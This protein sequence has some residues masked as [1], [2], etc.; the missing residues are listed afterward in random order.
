MTDTAEL[1]TT[2]ES[3]AAPLAAGWPPPTGATPFPPPPPADLPEYRPPAVAAPVAPPVSPTLPVVP[4]VAAA[5]PPRPERPTALPDYYS[6]VTPPTP[7]RS[8]GTGRKFLRFVVVLALLGGL[9]AAGVVYGPGVLER[10]R[11]ERAG[12]EPGG[13]AA[14]PDESSAPLEFPSQTAPPVEV[15]NATFILDDLGPDGTPRRYEITTDFISRASRVLI[16]RD[17]LPTLEVLTLFD[18]AVVRRIDEDTWYQT[19]RGQFPLDDQLER[20]RWV[21]HLDEL[22][23]PANRAAAAIENSTTS[24]LA[25]ES[26]RH[27]VVSIDPALLAGPELTGPSL[28][29]TGVV[30]GAAGDATA[31]PTQ[32]TPITPDLAP[33]TGPATGVGPDGLPTDGAGADPAADV[34]AL[35]AASTGRAAPETISIEMWIDARGLIRQLIT[36]TPG[37][38]ETLTVT[39]VS[40][41]EWLPEFPALEQIEPLTASAL[42]KLGL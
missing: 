39:M 9:G 33:A 5:P 3:P 28:R 2:R 21:R 20:D 27:L 26:M 11:E 7:K 24:Q 15:R 25:G 8:R 12:G 42:V 19:P 41:D 32:A 31:A 17:E 13:Q 30:G 10:I 38:D 40:A 34:G 16:D 23:P 14:A 37:G 1:V 18:Q 36:S 6:L 35:P 29:V 22:I 4:P